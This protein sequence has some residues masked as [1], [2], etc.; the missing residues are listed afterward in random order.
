M[1]SGFAVG[2]AWDGSFL[3]EWGVCLGMLDADEEEVAEMG[4]LHGTS[5]EI[6]KE[7]N[8][9]HSNSGNITAPM[10]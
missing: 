7:V 9:F 3:S 6:T 4:G 5:V 8:P 1:G 10:R 2:G